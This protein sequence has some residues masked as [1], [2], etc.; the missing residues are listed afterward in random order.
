MDEDKNLFFFKD[1]DALFFTRSCVPRFDQGF[2]ETIK[3]FEIYLFE[4]V[5]N[6]GSLMLMDGHR[7][8]GY[9]TYQTR[10]LKQCQDHLSK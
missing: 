7:C 10:I 3:E 9:P 1:L 2:F 8:S 4:P 5:L 6:S